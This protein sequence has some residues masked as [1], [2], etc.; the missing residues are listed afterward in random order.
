M[1]RP[2]FT[3]RTAWDRTENPLSAL[4]A[5][6]RAQGRDLVDL[7][8]SNPTRCHIADTAPLVSL[9]GHARGASYA[10]L[11]LGHPAAREAVAAAFR[12][13]GL[14]ACADRVV[15]S[16][17]TSEAYG[18]LFKLLCERGDRVLVPSP[19]YPLFDFL[20]RLEDVELVPYP[21]VAEE[22]WRIDL[23]AVERAADEAEGRARAIVLV[24]PN[25]PTGTFVRRAE[26]QALEAIA[27]A[28][29]MALIVDEV[30]AEF[31]HG[32]LPP[33]RLSSFAGE[34]EA[35]T[36][37]LGGLSKSLLLPQLKL[38]WTLACGPDDLVA[39]ALGRLEFLADTYLSV[40]TPVQ[41]ALPEILARRHS[42]QAAA[43]ARTAANL[44]ALDRAIARAGEEA[45]VRRLPSDGGWCAILE[46]PRTRSEDE[47][48]EI[49]VRDHGVIVHPGYFFD[50]DREGALVVSLLP[51]EETFAAAIGRVVSAV[52]HG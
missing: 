16:A 1:A 35:L 18:W 12:E 39:E 19:S 44:A 15:L 46:V 26:S 51:P 38:G 14:M 52:A 17:S 47:W 31:P 40:A 25:N 4:I 6:A 11:P 22:G 49:L 29:G 27:A 24:H 5:V 8:E 9:L 34:R 41:L 50:M 37:V 33:D 32:A 42:I 21:L 7:T 45:A 10:P 48:V 30:F 36:F 3:R 13:R 28:R 43:R 2:P 23:G 20:A